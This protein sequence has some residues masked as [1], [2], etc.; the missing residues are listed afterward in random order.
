MRIYLKRFF[1]NRYILYTL[2][3]IFVFFLWLFLS[4]VVFGQT[5]LFPSPGETFAKFTSLLTERYT[6]L[7]IGWSLLRTL[8]GF[9]ISLAAALIVGI[10]AGNFKGL[11]LFLKPLI[12]ILKSI[13]T[14]AFVFL[15]L[16]LSG[17]RFAPTYIVFLLS[18]PIL[19]ESI[20]GGIKSIPSDILD[21]AR[22]DGAPI[23]S[24]I[25]VIKLPLAMPYVS[26]GLASSF[27]LSLKT[28]IMAEI[29]TG[30]TN[31]GLGCMISVYRNLDPTD[32]TPIFAIALIALIIVVIT[33]IFGMLIDKYFD[34]ENRYK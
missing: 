32:L 13:P 31:Y 20:A 33:D 14:A 26:V 11:Y 29:I 9:A 16:A 23:L 15:F 4:K 22:V 34:L 7:S 28:E 1:T 25:F 24:T 12:G 2:G 18:F 21:A 19:Y 17:S 27:A 8:I 6:W 10:F 5:Y 30:D 3:F